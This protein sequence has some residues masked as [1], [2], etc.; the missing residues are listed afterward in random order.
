MPKDPDIADRY[1][2]VLED[3]WLDG[4][5]ITSTTFTASVES[6]LTVTSISLIESPQVSALFSGGNEGFWPIKIRVETA[7]RQR[8]FCVTLWVKQGC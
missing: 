6:G 2:F 7:T 1:G 4:E 8:E 5:A 3:G